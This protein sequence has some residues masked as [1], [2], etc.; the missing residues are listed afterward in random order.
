MSRAIAHKGLRAKETEIKKVSLGEA[1]TVTAEKDAD[2]VALDE[3]R[4]EERIRP[5]SSVDALREPLL[6]S[7]PILKTRA[8]T[9]SWVT[10][11]S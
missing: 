8:A 5:Y 7:R 9:S 4:R 3:A 1:F 10:D 11:R 2:L 6:S